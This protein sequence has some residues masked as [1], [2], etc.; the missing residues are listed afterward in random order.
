M[1]D[2]FNTERFTILHTQYVKM[3]APNLGMI[4]SG[5]QDLGS[6]NFIAPSLA[7]RMSRSTKI[8][9]FYVPGTKF[10]RNR[11]LQYEN[12]TSQIKF[13]DY[14]FIIY[15]YG[16]YGSVDGAAV[17]FNVAYLNDCFIRMH[18]KDA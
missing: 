15:A 12:Q 6:G 14:H 11:I 10:S 5:I 8:V 4:A 13:F 3:R 9:Q 16:N 2:T 7:P 1:L 18:Y 17:A